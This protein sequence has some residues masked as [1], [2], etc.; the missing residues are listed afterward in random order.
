MRKPLTAKARALISAN[1]KKSWADRKEKLRIKKLDPSYVHKKKMTVPNSA[2]DRQHKRFATN[3]LI[4]SAYQGYCEHIASGYPKEAWGYGVGP[5]SVSYI[6]MERYI[7]NNPELCPVDMMDNAVAASYKLWFETVAASARGENV[8]ANATSLTLI[9]R[10]IHGWDKKEEK[11]DRTD[12]VLTRLDAYL[13]NA[14]S[15]A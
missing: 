7:K 12:E 4:S 8:K 2:V 10:N 15:N 3:D 6:T 13:E 11:A 1:L 5:T 9:M 14:K